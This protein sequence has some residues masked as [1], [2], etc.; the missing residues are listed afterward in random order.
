M[1]TLMGYDKNESVRSLL[2]DIVSYFINLRQGN[3]E[4]S[5]LC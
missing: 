4:L 5:T 2:F 1:S 3:L